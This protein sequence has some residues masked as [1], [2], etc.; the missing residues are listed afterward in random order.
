M[1][2]SELREKIKSRIDELKT[3][4]ERYDGPEDLIEILSRYGIV[5]FTERNKAS[6][7][8]MA[9][10]FPEWEEKIREMYED[11]DKLVEE[12]RLSNSEGR[13]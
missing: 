11:I 9:S 8:I 3:E 4:V 2:E 7:D 5:A 12:H 10:E 1:N 13:Q 6:R